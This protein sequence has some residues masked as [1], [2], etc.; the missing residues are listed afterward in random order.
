MRRAKRTQA[1]IQTELRKISFLGYCPYSPSTWGSPSCLSFIQLTRNAFANTEQRATLLGIG[2][3]S[4]GNRPTQQ[5]LCSAPTELLSL[6]AE[7]PVV[8]LAL[9]N[10][11]QTYGTSCRTVLTT[12]YCTAG[13]YFVQLVVAR[14]N[15]TP[16]TYSTGRLHSQHRPAR[17]GSAGYSSVLYCT[18]SMAD[19]YQSLSSHDTTGQRT[20]Q[21]VPFRPASALSV[22]YRVG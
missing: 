10:L 18:V 1:S 14:C 2:L 16:T 21:P 12:W 17:K 15:D 13:L 6:I 19:R 11:N 22:W 9:L 4:E 8:K 3:Y 7:S 20:N 5:K